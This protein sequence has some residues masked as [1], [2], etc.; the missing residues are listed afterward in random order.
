MTH[1][2]V[3]YSR[4]FSYEMDADTLDSA[5]ARATNF[6]IGM[7]KNLG[8]PVKILSIH[9]DTYVASTES[10]A[11]PPTKFEKLV[12]GMRKQIDYMLE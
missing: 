1:Y 12:S 8:N 4:T 3:V 11:S 9:P 5:A 10:V 7:S 2:I 6:A